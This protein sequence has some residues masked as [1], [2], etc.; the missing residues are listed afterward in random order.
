MA[1]Y[2]DFSTNMD[3]SLLE[4]IIKMVENAG[5]KESNPKLVKY[6]TSLFKRRRLKYMCVSKKVDLQLNCLLCLVDLWSFSNY[7]CSQ[8]LKNWASNIQENLDWFSQVRGVVCDMG[9]S[10]F[11]SELKI[12]EG[13]GSKK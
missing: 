7:A 4:K 1:I 10:T 2:Y 3:M 5:A 6:K 13:K 11:L 9:N 8:I 12:R